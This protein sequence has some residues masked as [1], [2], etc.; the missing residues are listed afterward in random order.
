MAS[1]RAA[2]IF[3]GATQRCSVLIYRSI[4]L[5]YHQTSVAWPISP[6]HHVDRNRRLGD[7]DTELEQ[8]AMNLGGTPERV[9]KTH[10]SD[11]IAHLFINPRSSPTR[12][13]LPSPI[14]GKT[15]SMP[16]HNGLRPDDRYGIKNAWTATIEPNE[17]GAVG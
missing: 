5:A 3:G 16:T 8:L 1:C 11:Q 2:R 12:T 14:G 7:L 9:L 4:S 13:G 10:S 17:Q 6:G 15:H